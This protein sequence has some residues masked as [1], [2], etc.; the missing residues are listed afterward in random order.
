[1][2]DAL[3]YLKALGCFWRYFKIDVVPLARAGPEHDSMSGRHEYLPARSWLPAPQRFFRLHGRSHVV[4]DWRHVQEV[5]TAECTAMGWPM[6]ILQVQ[7]V[8]RQWGGGEAGSVAPIAY[9]VV[10]LPCTS[11][12]HHLRCTCMR[13]L[14]RNC[15]GLFSGASLL[16]VCAGHM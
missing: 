15:S 8:R 5:Q 3:V 16:H 9:G 2:W 6:L 10:P 4:K 13:V 11:G 1:M 12:Y 14:P 7:E